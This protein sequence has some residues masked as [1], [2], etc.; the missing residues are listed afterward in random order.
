MQ[1]QV[2]VVGM[3]VYE[4]GLAQAKE[5]LL[6]RGKTSGRNDDNLDSIEKRFDTF[7]HQTLPVL[8]EFPPVYRISAVGTPEDVFQATKHVIGRLTEQHG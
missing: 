1:D 7:V 5:R 3:L 8:D 4:L 2:N 6:Q